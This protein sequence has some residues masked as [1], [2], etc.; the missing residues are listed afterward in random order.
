MDK[1]IAVNGRMANN[2]VWS[3]RVV[4]WR[5]CKNTQGSGNIKSFREDNDP[6]RSF[7]K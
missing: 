2:N 5:L 1:R 6:P 3:V 7:R 4:I